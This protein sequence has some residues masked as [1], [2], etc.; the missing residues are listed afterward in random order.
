MMG[1][2]GA[3]AGALLSLQGP[4]VQTVQAGTAAA[5]APNTASAVRAVQPPVIDG[6]DDD[7]AWRLATPV[8]AFKEWQPNEGRE[9]RFRTEA[10]IAYDAA[11]LYVFIRAF[12]PHPD[13]I[14][15]QLARRDNWPPTDK[16]GLMVD[17]YHDRRTAWEFWVNP[18]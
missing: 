8:T 1:V 4:Q 7:A 18:S 14:V 11:N 17:S 5:P 6:R 2:V 10:R 12:D 16:I 13:S 15:R 9:P 3:L